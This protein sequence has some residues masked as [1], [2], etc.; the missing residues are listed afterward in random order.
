M[1]LLLVALAT[2]LLPAAEDDPQRIFDRAVAVQTPSGTTAPLIAFEA[3]YHVSLFE[4]DE[5]GGHRIRSGTIRQRWQR[6]GE[7]SRYR[8]TLRQDVGDELPMTYLH[9]GR[10]YWYQRHGEPARDLKSGPEYKKDHDALK[11]EIR[12]TEHL[13]E[14]FILA[15]LKKQKGVVL[16][17]GRKDV[18]VALSKRERKPVHELVL[19][20]PGHRSLVLRIG[21]EDHR[22]YE[23]EI[24]P[25]PKKEPVESFRFSFHELMDAP[26]LGR[27]LVP[28]RVEYMK[29]GRTIL[30]ANTPSSD[31]GASKH[32]RFNPPLRRKDFQ[33]ER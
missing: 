18:V 23:A 29:D 5:P 17:M 6:D 20:R 8:R 9:D 30:R 10:Q 1:H 4:Y 7:K 12:R 21:K 2:S 24:R 11:D 19:D 25:G 26:D 16:S 27:I 3:T 15:E 33:P 14:L 28:T 22:V 13:M 32:L 31:G